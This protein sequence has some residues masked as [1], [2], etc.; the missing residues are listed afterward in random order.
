MGLRLTPAQVAGHLQRGLAPVYV[1]AGEEP[2]LVQEALDAIRAKARREG[3]A[4]REV[5]EVVPGFDWQGFLEGVSTGSL[6]SAR[7]IVELQLPRGLAPGR[8]KSDDEPD[9][10][11]TEAS[12]GGDPRKLLEQLAGAPPADVLLIVVLGKLDAKARAARW[13]AALENAGASVYAWP[14]AAEE[15]PRWIEARLKAAGLNAEA[16]AVRQL[17]ERTE[18]NL[19]ACA[20]DIEKLKLLY[21]GA[22]IGPAEVAAAVADSARFD[23]FDLSDKILDGDADGAL[24]SLLRLRE[25]GIEL[26]EL[27]GALAYTL[28]QWAQAAAHYE[29]TRDAASA[30]ESAGIWRQRQARFRGALTRAKADQV[31]AW[32]QRLAGVDQAVKL[33]AGAR[34]WEDLITCVVQASGCRGLRSSPL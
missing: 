29:R 17:A 15:L 33:G 1:V 5:Y 16:E 3:F 23:A 32:V 30:L 2:L 10:A 14:V 31:F 25:E 7:R 18:G 6:F 24:R 9:E 28:R 8:R 27:L 20:Q 22:R 26:P 12:G 21:P 11:G 19:L 4:E 34:A 13:F